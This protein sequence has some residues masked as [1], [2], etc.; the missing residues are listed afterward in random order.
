MADHPAYEMDDTPERP[1]RARPAAGDDVTPAELEQE[2]V[3]HERHQACVGGLRLISGFKYRID[4]E[5]LV[6][7][8][9][10]GQGLAAATRIDAWTSGV[11]AGMTAAVAGLLAA[12]VLWKRSRFPA[13]QLEALPLPIDGNPPGK[14]GTLDAAQREASRR[15]RA[16]ELDRI[17]ELTADFTACRPRLR[18]ATA[19]AI[20]GAL[21]GWIAGVLGCTGAAVLAAAPA[22]TTG[23]VT[24]W[25]LARNGPPGLRSTPLFYGVLPAVA[26]L[27]AWVVGS[28]PIVF[29]G[30]AA[31]AVI[32]FVLRSRIVGL[33]GRT[34]TAPG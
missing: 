15:R 17:E 14:A 27:M 16:G 6:I 28:S 10:C 12:G 30:G 32:G 31:A 11:F 7:A 13:E 4:M 9:L 34:A 19:G 22:A 25:L 5:G 26:T 18:A 3:L 1:A 20:L 21:C 23:A 8:G 33:I 29:A 2:R 24:F